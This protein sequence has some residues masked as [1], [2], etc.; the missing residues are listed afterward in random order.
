MANNYTPLTIPPGVSKNGTSYQNKG[1]WIASAFVRWFERAMRPLGGWAPVL[2]TDEEPILINGVARNM[3]AWRAL[4]NTAYLGISTETNLYAFSEGVLTDI[5]PAGLTTGDPDTAFADSAYG[6]GPYGGGRY[7]RANPLEVAVIEA[8][9]WQLDTFGEALVGTL[10]SDGRLYVWTP[11]DPSAIQIIGDTPGTEPIDC[12]SVVVTP[13]RFLVALA[14]DGYPRQVRWA[15]QESLT[16][17]EVAV[18]GSNTAGDFDLEGNGAIMCAARGRNETVIWTETDLHALR[19]VGGTL[20]YGHERL[21]TNC[22]IISRH[23]Y[24]AID[25]TMIWMGNGNFFMY[26]GFVKPIPSDIG[27]Y[28]FKNM[29]VSQR[30]KIYATPVSQFGEIWWMVPMF[31]A[32]ECSHIVVWNYR[33]NHWRIDPLPRTGGVDRGAFD[34]PIMAATFNITIEDVVTY[35]SRIYTHEQGFTKIDIGEVFGDYAI[36]DVQYTGSAETGPL[37]VM[38]GNRTFMLR[39]IVPDHQNK[40][41]LDFYVHSSMTTDP[42]DEFEDGPF[43]TDEPTDIRL[44]ARQ[45]RIEVRETADGDWRCGEMRVDVVPSGERA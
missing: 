14:A 20:V 38:G 45:M 30:A 32:V 15:S 3:L 9:T 11:G 39:E 35:Y 5:S 6:D 37:E 31:G 13:E 1:R 23:A 12:K 25:G 28:V 22:G 34:N 19:Y 40:G 27:D 26:D 4:N 21:G 17:W 2:A 10:S 44:T 29:S 18:D 33:E 24:A 42:A 8:G 7:G 41:S 36:G 16:D 43:P